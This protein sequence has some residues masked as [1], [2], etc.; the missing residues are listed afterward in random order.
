M[1]TAPILDIGA[2]R[3]KRV[4]ALDWVDPLAQITAAMASGAPALE[5]VDECELPR[6]GTVER[7]QRGESLTIAPP[8]TMDWREVGQLGTSAHFTGGS[9]LSLYAQY[10]ALLD[11]VLDELVAEARCRP[12]SS[13]RRST[14]EPPREPAHGD[15]ATNAAMVLAKAAGTNPRALA[16]ADQRRSSRRCRRSPRSRSPGPAS[17][18]CGSHP[19]PGATSSRTILREGD[20]YGLSTSARTSGSMSNMSRPTRPGRCTWAIAAARWSATAWRGCSRR[21]ASGSPRNI[22]STT[23]ARRSIRSPARSHLRYREALGEDIGEIPEGM[24]P[25]DYLVPVGRALAAEFGDRYRRR[26]REPNGC[27]CSA[28]ARDRGDARPDPPRPRACS[29]STTTNSRPKPSS[30]RRARSSAAME[31]AAR[32]GAGLPRRARA[33]QEPRRARRVGAGRADP[34]PLDPVRRRPGPADEEVGRQLDLFRLRRR[35]SSA[36]GARAPTIWSTSGA[37]T[38]PA[39]SSA[40]RRR[41]RR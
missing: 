26:A 3:M 39:R 40:S 6:L 29:A 15:L 12:G 20:D 25:G 16:E 24:Y 17:S 38:M 13:A 11:G 31:I 9:I 35:L 19:T 37:P 1:P 30:R 33:A 21:R 18:I 2:R 36:E 34:V 4:K 32:Q 27:R 22:M 8:L 41:S 10:A 23:P 14:V 5:L 28:T 7:A